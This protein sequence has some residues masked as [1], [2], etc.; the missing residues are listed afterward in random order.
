MGSREIA[1]LTGKEHRNVLRDCNNLN[2]SYTKMGLLI[3]EQRYYSHP[4]TGS[5]RHREMFL[6]K[7]QTM[8]LMTGYNIA[9]GKVVFQTL[10]TQKG[11]AYIASKLEVIKNPVKRVKTV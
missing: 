1:Q 6:S 5:Q 11:L 10:I 4:D 3:I 7:L 9:S 2:E 8:D